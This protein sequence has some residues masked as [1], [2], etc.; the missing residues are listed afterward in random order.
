[1]MMMVVVV[2]VVVVGDGAQ[3]RRASEHSKSPIHRHR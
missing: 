2:V 1:M 3:C